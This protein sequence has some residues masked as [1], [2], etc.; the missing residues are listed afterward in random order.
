MKPREPRGGERGL[1]LGVFLG[2]VPPKPGSCSPEPTDGICVC[3]FVEA[4]LNSVSHKRDK[5]STNGVLATLGMRLIHTD[6]LKSEAGYHGDP[7]VLPT[8]LSD[9]LSNP[10]LLPNQAHL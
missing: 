4:N 1:G 8:L 7:T 5:V 2:N 10:F 9:F 6:E 3:L